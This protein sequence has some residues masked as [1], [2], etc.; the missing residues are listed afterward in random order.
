MGRKNPA[1]PFCENE[2]TELDMTEQ[3]FHCKQCDS[4]FDEED[5]VREDLRHHLSRILH[6]TDEQHPLPC[7]ARIGE[8]EA[9]GLSTL[10]LPEVISCFQQN[11]G[12]IWV[13]IYGCEEPQDID[14]LPTEDIRTILNGLI[15]NN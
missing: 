2:N 4:L 8:G 1:C 5:I 13:N 3:R 14:D 9:C 6:K 11:D 15:E 7:G 10:E 12:T